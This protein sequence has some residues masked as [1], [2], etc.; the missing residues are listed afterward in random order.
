MLVLGGAP[1]ALEAHLARLDA[2]VGTLY[3]HHLPAATDRRAV[4]A[5]ADVAAAR[6]RLTYLPGDRAVEAV[7]REIDPA[8]VLPGRDRALDLRSV[9]LDGWDGRHKW[10]DRRLLEALEHDVAPAMPLLVAP[11]GA[12]LETSRASLF[13]VV[14]GRLITPRAAA[15]VLP[16]VVRAQVLELAATAGLDATEAPL[17]LAQLAGADEAFV[18]GAVRLLEPVRSLDDLPLPGPGPVTALLADRL[19]SRWLAPAG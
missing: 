13:A 9:E 4:A 3:G 10:A 1:V 8:I 15:R 16:G 6:L 11:G 19:R 14:G 2:S 18:T 17:T 7:A 5:A 12:V